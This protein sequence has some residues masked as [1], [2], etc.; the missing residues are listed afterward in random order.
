MAA[1]EF[2]PE[3]LL[4]A[5]ADGG[6]QCVLIGGMAA[7]V[8]GDVGV[9]LDL[10]IT[11][12]FDDDNVER[13][14][15]VLRGLRARI[16]VEGEPEGLPFDCSAEFLRNLGP[17]EILNL[18]TSCGDLD[19]TFTPSG[20]GG[21]EDLRRDALSLPVGGATMLVASLPDVIRSKEAAGRDKDR[22]ALPRLRAL[23]ERLRTRPHQGA[24]GPEDPG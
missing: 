13:L 15:A 3:R 11:P 18:T 16:R 10:D 4:A 9:T 17:E 12:A 2:D 5:L 22:V 19:L 21:Y 14:A 8:H 1:P 23:L 7:I 6:V 20:T 24:D